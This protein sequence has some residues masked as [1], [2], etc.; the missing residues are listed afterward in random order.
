MIPEHSTVVLWTAASL[1]KQI[2]DLQGMGG[3]RRVMALNG[4]LS[5]EFL[6]PSSSNWDLRV[7][8]P[9]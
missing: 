8:K 2:C 7:H 1:Q 6:L 9:L 4:L 3:R 5:L